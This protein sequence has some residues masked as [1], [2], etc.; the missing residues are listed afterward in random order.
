MSSVPDRRYTVEEYLELEQSSATRHE[1]YAGRI[2]AMAGAS[3]PHGIIVWNLSALL[4]T[5][6][7]DRGC[8]AI[9]NDLRVKAPTG[10]LTYPDVVIFCGK[11]E[12]DQA[13]AN[14]LLNP[15]VLVEV[16]SPSTEAYDRGKKFDEY[17]TIS[18]LKE[19]V[20]VAQNHPQILQF[21][22][23][24][25]S[26]NW[27]LSK[28]EGLHAAVTL[29]SIGCALPLSKIYEQIEFPDDFPLLRPHDPQASEP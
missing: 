10:F 13:W 24:S 16:L 7:P 6:L 4:K 21:S 3:L 12:I 17:S 14:T 8:V 27:V 19:Y 1:Y 20:L 5:E 18:S 22:R 11:P 29:Q 23:Q 15:T 9:P 2:Y 28:A 26:D 25:D